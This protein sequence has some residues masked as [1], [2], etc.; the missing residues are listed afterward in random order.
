MHRGLP[1]Y[2]STCQPL[3]QS[4]IDVQPT[5]SINNHIRH[6]HPEDTAQMAPGFMQRASMVQPAP[7]RSD[8]ELLTL[9]DETVLESIEVDLDKVSPAATKAAYGPAQ[10]E[11]RDWCLK[12]AVSEL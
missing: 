5:L 11:F 7:A 6:H 1:T 4:E 9:D 8:D 3:A 12:R 2:I 10:R